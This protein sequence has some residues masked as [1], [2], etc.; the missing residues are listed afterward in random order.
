MMTTKKTHVALACLLLAAG[1]A[2]AQEAKPEPS[3]K[4]EAVPARSLPLQLQVVL[5]RYRGE[6]KLS[7]LPYTL[8]LAANLGPARVRMGVQVP[9]RAAGE[10]EKVQYRDVGTNLD[11]SAISLDPERFRVNCTFEQSSVYSA[12]STTGADSVLPSAPV[13][14][15]PL[16]RSFRADAVLIL[17]D[18]QTGLH[19]VATDP[20]NGELLKAE[21]TLRLVK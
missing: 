4:E 8:V 1:G 5:S 3:K 11:C 15:V 14:S 7:S 19:T 20:V 10:P 2:G 12:S 18:G 9:I 13:A 17:K 21:V 6:Q 16:F